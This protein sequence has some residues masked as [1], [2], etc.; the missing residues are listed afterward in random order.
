MDNGRIIEQGLPKETL[1]DPK[2]E[3]TRRFLWR[4]LRSFEHSLE[5]VALDEEEGGVE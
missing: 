2:E 4:T 5:E 1:D 3:R